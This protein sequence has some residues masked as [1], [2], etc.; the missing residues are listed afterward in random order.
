MP[1]IRVRNRRPQ[2]SNTQI[3]FTTGSSKVRIDAS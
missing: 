1:P 2:M 3:G